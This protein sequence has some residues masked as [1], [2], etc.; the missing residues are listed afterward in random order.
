MGMNFSRGAGTSV[1]PD[2]QPPLKVTPPSNEGRSPLLHILAGA[3][4]SLTLARMFT[5]LVRVK[6]YPSMVL[7][8]ISL[9]MNEVKSPFVGRVFGFYFLLSLFQ[10]IVPDLYPVISNFFIHMHQPWNR[11]ASGSQI[12]L[13]E[14]WNCQCLV[15]TLPLLSQFCLVGH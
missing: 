14:L 3:W 5:I 9:V 15:S 11:Q 10:I 8:C 12:I 2:T 6:W 7:F 4:H 1:S 13:T